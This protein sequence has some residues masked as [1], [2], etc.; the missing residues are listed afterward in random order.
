MKNT[1]KKLIGQ[2]KVDTASFTGNNI[3][4]D[5]IALILYIYLYYFRS[6]N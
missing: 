2:S 6:T 5:S 3:T 1:K 4:F